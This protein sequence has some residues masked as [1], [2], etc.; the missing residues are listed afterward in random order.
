MVI[1]PVEERNNMK[2]TE[3]VTKQEEIT[4]YGHDVAADP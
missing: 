1:S 3:M 4:L 2:L